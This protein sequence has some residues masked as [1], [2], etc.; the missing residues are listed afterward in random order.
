MSRNQY[1]WLCTCIIISTNTMKSLGKGGKRTK[2]DNH[3]GDT[4]NATT[5]Q[6]SIGR[7]SGSCWWTLKNRACF[8]W[9]LGGTFFTL[10]NSAHNLGKSWES[11]VS[12]YCMTQTG[13]TCAKWRN[14]G[15]LTRANE[16]TWVLK[17]YHRNFYMFC[18]FDLI[19]IRRPLVS[20]VWMEPIFMG[21][22]W[23]Q[24]NHMDRLINGS[25]N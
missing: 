1:S 4:D 21:P 22:W 13:Q 6:G 12:S 16:D 17:M 18:F 15:T 9:G 8:L 14:Q 3:L 19:G 20:S 11:W 24:S 7:L 2:N 5:L 10:S 25:V 23:S